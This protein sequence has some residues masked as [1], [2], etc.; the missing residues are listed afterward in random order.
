MTRI[1]VTLAVAAAVV[2][3]A[4]NRA[5]EKDVD[6]GIVLWGEV[7]D[8]YLD[9]LEANQATPRKAIDEGQKFI[10]TDAKVQRL[11]KIGNKPGT[12]AQQDRFAKAVEASIPAIQARFEKVQEAMVAAGDEAAAN[13]LVDQWKSLLEKMGGEE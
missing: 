2:A 10:D 3:L 13:A 12:E 5:T 6:E 4:C 11:A 1:A 8:G 7:S 9:V